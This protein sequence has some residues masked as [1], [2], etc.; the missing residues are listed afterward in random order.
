MLAISPADVSAHTH[1]HVVSFLVNSAIQLQSVTYSGSACI[2]LIQVPLLC[3]VISVV[4]YL[5]AT[6]SIAC[7][8]S[9]NQTRSLPRRWLRNHR[10]ARPES[11]PFPTC[12]RERAPTGGSVRWARLGRGRLGNATVPAFYAPVL[13]RERD[14]S[15]EKAGL[16]NQRREPAC[17]RPFSWPRTSGQCKC[18]IGHLLIHKCTQIALTLRTGRE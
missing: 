16:M 10:K 8:L 1:A 3:S 13:Y 14:I 17:I 2:V 7:W 4:K 12:P 15:K 9:E 18:D 11:R 6:C 5:L